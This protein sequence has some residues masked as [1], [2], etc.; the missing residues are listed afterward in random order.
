VNYSKSKYSAD[1][2]SYSFENEEIKTLFKDALNLR[3]GAEYRYEAYRARLGYSLQGKT[4]RNE[5]DVDNSITSISGGLGYRGKNFF[6]DFAL[7]KSTSPKYYYQPYNFS[8][9]SGPIAEL[10]PRSTTG[11]ITL[12]FTF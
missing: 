11:M 9:G 4:F 10:K 6:I 2:A 8:D 5:F 7:I 12:G 3:I 1:G